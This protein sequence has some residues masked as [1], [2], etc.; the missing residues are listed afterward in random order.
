MGLAKAF[1]HLKFV[2]QDRGVVV[3][4][5][6]KVRSF[7]VFV[8]CFFVSFCFLSLLPLHVFRLFPHLRVSFFLRVC[9]V[10]GYMGRETDNCFIFV[11][12][13]V[14]IDVEGEGSRVVDFW[15]C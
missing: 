4:M 2:V 14:G 8:F 11:L 5:G 3:D 6:V 15:D 7:F 1:G 12:L 13:F 9:P 10:I